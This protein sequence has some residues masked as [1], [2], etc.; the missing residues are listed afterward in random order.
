MNVPVPEVFSISPALW[1][2]DGLTTMRRLRRCSR[3]RRTVQTLRAFTLV[4]LLVVIAI[5]GVLVGLLLPA[6]QAAREASRRATCQ[7]NLRQIGLSVQTYHDAQGRI[8]WS[9]NFEY[10]SG[11]GWIVLTL[12]HREQQAVYDQ[13]EPYFEG[14]FSVRRGGI[15]HPD[16][17]AVVSRPIAGFRCPSDQDA[18]IPTSID[19]YQ[20]KRQDMALTNYKG[21]IGDTRMGNAGSGTPDCHRGPNCTGLFWRFS[22]QVTIGF[23]DIADGLSKTFLAGEDLPRYNWHSGL[24]YGNGDYSS[25]HYPLNVKPIPPDPAN[26]PLSMTFR[27]DHP[28][29]GHFAFCDSSVVF[30]N[31]SIDFEVYQDLSTRAGDEIVDGYLP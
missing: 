31:E 2:F 11:R 17:E 10:Q 5:I 30:I 8:P 13:L 21:V 4:E 22:F 15:N 14:N 24:Y 23:H 9:H 16:L 20:W 26:W 12:P 18:S 3:D 6:V 7:N 25:T 1:V 28:G 27:S 19:Q 29:G